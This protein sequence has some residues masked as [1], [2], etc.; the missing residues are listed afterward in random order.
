MPE[1]GQQPTR[2]QHVSGFGRTG[3]RV[4]PVPG[5][6]RDDRIEPPTGGLPSLEGRH[7]DIDASTACELGHPPVGLDAQ[8]GATSR[9][10][11]PG[12]DAGTAADVE[13]LA[14][15]ARGNDPVDQRCRIP[16]PG[17]VVAPGI[18]P[19]RFRHLAVP[20]DFGRTVRR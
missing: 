19:E 18:D 16:R 14:P 8:H 1:R 11:L 9:Q 6:S 15:R 13:H 20:M 2:P 17:P 7:F 5:L 10:E 3:H 12:F 4:H